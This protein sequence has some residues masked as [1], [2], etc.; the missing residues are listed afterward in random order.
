M[1]PL[2]SDCPSSEREDSGQVISQV[3]KEVAI[4]FFPS[5]GGMEYDKLGYFDI[6]VIY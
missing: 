5:K 3:M 4:P 6:N 2:S 1:A